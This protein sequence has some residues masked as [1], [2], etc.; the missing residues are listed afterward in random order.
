MASFV[1]GGS[2]AFDQMMYAP[3]LRDNIEFLQ[4]RS[5]TITQN[6]TEAGRNFFQGARETW[7]DFFG[8][9]AA[10]LARA[11]TRNVAS[12]WET[13][14]V[15][16][17]ETI[18][19]MQNA[20]LVMQRGIM[21]DPFIKDMYL[22]QK[23]DGYSDTYVNRYGDAQGHDN[24]DYRRVNDG[25]VL[26]REDGGYEAWTYFEELENPEDELYFD[27]QVDMHH[28]IGNIVRMIRRG[29]DDPTSRFN[30]SL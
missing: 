18:G 27:Q 29:K 8:E 15:R 30:S 7:N 19:H 13:N 20:P 11:V 23:I 9:G 25:M 28:S 2:L 3:K 21:S 4:N 12:L 10:R 26:E 16:L 5:A 22:R 1:E 14:V 24:Y 17:L 6:L